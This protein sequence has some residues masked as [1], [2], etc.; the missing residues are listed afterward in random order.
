MNRHSPSA[1]RS[2]VAD[3]ALRPTAAAARLAL[4]GLGCLAAAAASPARAE[5]SVATLTLP[6]STIELGIGNTSQAAAKAH[7]YDGLTRRGAYFI[8]H[9]DLRGGGSYDSASASRWRIFGNNLGTESRSLGFEQAEQGRGRVS[10]S[11]D[12]LQRNASDTYQT[13]LLGVGSNALTLP[14]SWL[15]PL[16]PRVSAT[17]ANA[18]GLLPAVTSSSA[19]VNGVLTAPTAAQLAQAQAIQVADLPLFQPVALGTKRTRL[20]F[21]ALLNLGTRWELVADIRHENRN[22]L[23]AMGTVTRFTGAD[24]STIIPDRID[25]S[26]EQLSF[27]AN[28]TGDDLVL[29]GQYYLSTLTNNVPSMSWANWATPGATAN[30]QTMGSAPSNALHQLSLNGAWRIAGSTRLAG[31]ISWGRST[32]NDTLLTDISTPLVPVA[33][34][35][36]LVVNK[37][38]SLKLSSRPLKGLT[39]AAAYKHDERDNQTPVNTFGYYDA[40]E[41]RSGTSLFNAAFPSAGL[42]ANANLNAN[43]AYSRK[44]DQADVDAGYTLAP[45]HTLRAAAQFQKTERW[46]NGSWIACVDANTAKETTLRAD[47]VFN[48]AEAFSGRLG[49]AHGRRSVDYNENAFLALVPIA[50]VTPTGAPLGSTAYSTML[51]LGVTGYGPVLGLNPLPAT[52]SAAAFFFANNNA[53]ANSLYG[54]QNR[55]SELP[56]LRRYDMADRNRDTLRSALTWQATPALALQAALNLNRDDYAHSVYGLQNARGA[57]ATLDASY[58]ASDDSSLAAFVTLDDQRST[59]AGNS[60]TANS[61]ATS[62]NGFTAISGG[63]FSTIALRNASNKVDPCLNWQSFV[64]DRVATLGL[65]ATLKSLAGG[66]LDLTGSLAF[67]TARSAN[68]MAGGNYANNP[69]AVT[70]A[71][72]GTVAAFFIPATA[73]P[74]VTTRTLDLRAGAKWR[75]DESRSLR[76]G[77]RYQHMRSSDWA[78]D[79][80]QFGGLAGV[81][82]TLQQAPAY[83]VHTVGVSFVYAYR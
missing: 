67:S 15:V 37:A 69:L 28:Y 48:V 75:L 63:C 47:Y 72:A 33:S 10:V 11:Y 65:A 45:G 25:Q 66:K 16:V 8:G 44:L 81:L 42:G 22:G 40:G 41:L 73:L 29:Q 3:H 9:F 49:L 58:A 52:G 62:V 26:H 27:G 30:S 55:I 36:A 54:N 21:N 60:Y 76:L 4:L 32:Q 78:Y 6:A 19:L 18:R 57:S 39:L 79:G 83:T 38:A 51:A 12:E 53:L 61:T 82:P 74:D 34:A 13:P 35:N 56:G 1:L 7:E 14:G 17:A 2:R 80:L 24:I 31:A 46:C 23:K 43:R 71:P 59:S 64:R 68:D 77:Y 70:G 5:D 50:N 20:E